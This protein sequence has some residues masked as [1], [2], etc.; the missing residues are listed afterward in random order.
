MEYKTTSCHNP[1]DLNSTHT[2][3][4][5]WLPPVAENDGPRSHPLSRCVTRKCHLICYTSTRYQQ[6]LFPS[7]LCAS[8]WHPTSTDPSTAKLLNSGHHTAFTNC[9]VS[10]PWQDYDSVVPH[11][12]CKNCSCIPSS[13]SPLQSPPAVLLIHQVPLFSNLQ[14]LCY[15]L[16][17]ETASIQ[18]CCWKFKYYTDVAITCTWQQLKEIKMEGT[19][20]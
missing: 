12:P 10:F 20:F 13:L 5:H 3:P 1:E 19:A 4:F 6:R 17:D 15:H 2:M 14:L 18:N 8:T 9:H 11:P 16:L 7:P